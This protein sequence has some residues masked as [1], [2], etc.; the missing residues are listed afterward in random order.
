MANNIDV[1]FTNVPGKSNFKQ[2]NEDELISSIEPGTNLG[3]ISLSR[4]ADI[5][6]LFYV[7]DAMENEKN[8]EE[9]MKA[10]EREEIEKFRV[11]SSYRPA[12]SSTQRVGL[13]NLKK[14]DKAESSNMSTVAVKLTKKRKISDKKE[15]VSKDSKKADPAGALPIP[16]SETN[17]LSSSEI[18]GV[19]VNSL[20][21][22]M[23]AY[24]DD[25]D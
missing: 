3:F 1:A 16:D 20:S 24:E 17:A 5:S 12:L 18:F 19:N 15:L 22:L 25:S 8:D 21:N 9:K 6:D 13:I 10:H 2:K 4:D 14:P 11:S 23:G 7:R